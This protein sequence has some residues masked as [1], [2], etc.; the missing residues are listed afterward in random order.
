MRH[1]GKE[2]WI[3]FK[4]GHLAKEKSRIMENHLYVCDQ[5]LETFLELITDEEINDAAKKVSPAFDK[6]VM[7]AI[8]KNEA[9]WTQ[10]GNTR[11]VLVS[12]KLIAYYVACAMVTIMLMSA[13][14]FQALAGKAQALAVSSVRQEKVQY[15]VNF[16][17]P[18]EIVEKT[19]DFIR[20]FEFGEKGGF[21]VE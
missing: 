1:F 14:F 21:N 20:N 19:S 17:W 9:R 2:E 4:S 15:S 3:L 11:K 7:A 10:R 13:G 16:S 18:L 8:E 5:C 6:K 12:N